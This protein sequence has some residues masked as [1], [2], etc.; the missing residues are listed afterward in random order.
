MLTNILITITLLLITAFVL[1]R[2]FTLPR[3]IWI[4]FISQPLVMSASPIIV[5]IGGILSSKMANDPSLATLPITL[6]IL[7]VAAGSIPAAMLAK[8]KGRKFAVYTGLSCS[9]IAVIVALFSAKLALFEL[10]CFASMLIGIGGAFTQQLRFAAIES[11]LNK[12]DVPKILSILMLSGV[13]AAFLGPEVAVAGK[14]WLNSPYGYA[15]SFLFLAALILCAMIMMLA[16]KNPPVSANETIGE[17]RELKVIAKQPIFLIAVC[18]ATIGYA[19]M[20][21]LMTATPIS[22]HHIQGHSLQETKWVIQS[23]IAAMYIPSLFTPWLV[24]Y[25]KL[26][27]LMVI[28]ISIYA[29]VALIALSGHEVMHYWWALILLGIG[30]NFLFLTG[31][32]LLPES[33]HASERHKVQATNDFVLFGFQAVASLLAGWVLFNAGWHWVVITSLPFILVLFTVVGFYHKHQ[34]KLTLNMLKTN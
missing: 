27:G 33:Y 23:H 13:F 8:N 31:T 25:L 34:K 10:F 32:S 7:G 9:L 18:T 20:S 12:E 5:F 2:V 19:L 14:D 15:G 4:L 17:P 22:M 1:S 3:N 28:G 6:M 24:K 11:S 30:W 16:F 26:K 29:V 21:Y